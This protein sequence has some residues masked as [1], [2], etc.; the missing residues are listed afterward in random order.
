M[1]LIRYVKR[2]DIDVVKW[3]QCIDHA[4]NGLIYAYSFYLDAVCDHWDALIFE[5]Y[6]AVMP[7]PWR[8]KWGINY[9]YQPPFVQQ[10]GV[11]GN[12]L[13]E[14]LLIF[15]MQKAVHHFSFLHYNISV[16]IKVSQAIYFQRSNFI[17]DLSSGYTTIYTSYT[18]ECSK[19]IRKAESRNC[20]YSNNIKLDEVIQNFRNA[21]GALNNNL[22]DH[23]YNKFKTLVIN[24]QQNEMAFLSGVKDEMGTT[25]YSAAIFKD[26][27]RIYYVLGAPTTAGREKRATY[28]FI[29]QVLKIHAGQPLL[30][31]FEGSDIPNVASFYKK[32]GPETEH[33][34]EV[35][36][37]ALPFPLKWLKR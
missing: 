23:D 11:F 29:D 19:N 14:D 6:T 12:H 8:R 2:K 18:N 10:L 37:N 31:D 32:F 35:K 3:D 27:K 13:T 1:N 36:I 33:Y 4:T 24:C 30:F 7:L 16:P 28:F 34:Y 17:I 15:F 5:D 22:K 26:R 20:V 25:L 21:Y 9:V